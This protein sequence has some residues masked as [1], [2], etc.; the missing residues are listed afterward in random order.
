MHPFDELRRNRFIRKLRSTAIAITTRRIGPHEGYAKMNYLIGRIEDILP[1]QEIHLE[2]CRK[3]DH[4]IMNYP[5]GE[6]RQHYNKEYL[7]ALDLKLAVIDRK[8]QEMLQE[9]CLEIIEK[10]SDIKDRC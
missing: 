3:Y 7:A 1:L 9:K 5:I 10:F 4:E 6:E 8:Y 2:V